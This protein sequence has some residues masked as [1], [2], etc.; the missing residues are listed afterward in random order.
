MAAAHAICGMSGWPQRTLSAACPDGRSARYLDGALAF[1][2][3]DRGIELLEQACCEEALV[4]R[5]PA[6]V[7]MLSTHGIHR[8]VR[9]SA[10]GDARS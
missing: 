9:I 5:H 10:D 4:V 3:I 6:E 2:R 7:W 8:S 1:A